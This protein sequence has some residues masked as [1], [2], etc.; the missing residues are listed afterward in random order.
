[1][2]KKRKSTR[3]FSSEKTI[4]LQD[5]LGNTLRRLTEEELQNML[6]FN[7]P[8][9]RI[10]K[11]CYRRTVPVTPSMA[12][13]SKAALSG[14]HRHGLTAGDGGDMH[15]LAGHYF[16]DGKMSDRDRE[17]F[18]GWAERQA[19]PVTMVAKIEPSEICFG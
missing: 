12:T 5:E 9:Q 8:I 3:F 7:A 13:P 16:R 19:I 2:A 17:R 11:V 14:G 1:M 4:E 15:K 18:M 10:S 6:A